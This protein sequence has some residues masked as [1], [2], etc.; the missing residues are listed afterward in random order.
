VASCVDRV[1]REYADLVAE[2]ETAAQLCQTDRFYALAVA[3]KTTLLAAL[4][5]SNFRI[6]PVNAWTVYSTVQILMASSLGTPSLAL[7][8]VLAMFA[9]SAHEIHRD[10]A[11]RQS[12]SLDDVFQ[13]LRACSTT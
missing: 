6:T 4:V 2:G 5:Y 10:Q 7:G 13:W 1:A 8:N 11:R 9:A 12:E 3:F